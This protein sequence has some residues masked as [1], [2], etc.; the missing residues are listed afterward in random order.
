MV[1][2]GNAK[3]CVSGEVSSKHTVSVKA[4]LSLV[5]NPQPC[6]VHIQDIVATGLSPWGE[7]SLRLWDGTSYSDYVWYAYDDDEGSEGLLDTLKDGWGDND[8]KSVDVTIPAG[9]GFWIVSGSNATLTFPNAV[10]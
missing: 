7:D 8:Q 1:T 10:Q 5:C 9:Q 4:G 6:A 2:T 3:V